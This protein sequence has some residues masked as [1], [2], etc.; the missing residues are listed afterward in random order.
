MEEYTNSIQ[1]PSSSL[2]IQIKDGQAFEHPITEENLKAVFK[3]FDPNN[4]SENYARFVRKEPP[5]PGIFQHVQ[6]KYV[7]NPDGIWQD[8]YTLVEMT[9][10]E[11]NEKRKLV[12]EGFPYQS[13]NMDPDTLEFSPPVPP[14][15][16]TEQWYWDE[17]KK[18][19]FKPEVPLKGWSYDPA[20]YQWFPPKP[21]PD[22]NRVY[23]WD[24]DTEDWK[25]ETRELPGPVPAYTNNP[26]IKA[27]E[28]N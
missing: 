19:W 13:W 8:E 23:V 12:K 1:I 18:T 11:K 22:Y 14:P 15:S 7:K 9:E 6:T 21:W 17:E 4:P 27:L 16:T 2:F 24:N 10:E 5:V 3:D 28:S 20:R 25:P 26:V